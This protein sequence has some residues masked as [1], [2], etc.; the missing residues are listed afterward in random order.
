MAVRNGSLSMVLGVWICH[1]TQHHFMY[2]GLMTLPSN[3]VNHLNGTVTKNKNYKKNW[4][5]PPSLSCWRRLKN[6]AWISMVNYFEIIHLMTASAT[7]L[8]EWKL[9][10]QLCMHVGGQTRKLHPKNSRVEQTREDNTEGRNCC[11]WLCST[12]K[13]SG[14]SFCQQQ[15]GSKKGLRLL[16]HSLVPG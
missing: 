2:S 11:L 13:T 1:Y 7:K 5:C 8:K 9:L 12:R 14:Q 3:C 16:L 15:E 4:N 10:N 6:L